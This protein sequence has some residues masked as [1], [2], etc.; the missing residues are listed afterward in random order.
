MD[1]PAGGNPQISHRMIPTAIAPKDRTA[2]RAIMR[3]DG[4][5]DAECASFPSLSDFVQPF[6]RFGHAVQAGGDTVTPARTAAQGVLIGLA[7]VV[8][9]IL[10]QDFDQEGGLPRSL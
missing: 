1:R 3:R 6:G 5:E 4:W 8:W 7:Q 10:C 9:S 2:A